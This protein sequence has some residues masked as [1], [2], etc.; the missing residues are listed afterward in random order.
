MSTQDPR[1]PARYPPIEPYE[2]GMLDVGDG[3]AST[4]RSAAT[5]PASRRWCCTAARAPAAAPGFGATP[6]PLATGSC[7][8]TSGIA[9]GAYRTP[10][11]RRPISSTNTTE[12]LLGDLE[13]F[14]AP[15]HR[16]LAPLRRFV[17]G[18]LGLVYAERHPDRVSEMVLTSIATGR[19]AETDL[20]TRGLGVMFPELGPFRGRRPRLGPRRPPRRRLRPTTGRPRP[21]GS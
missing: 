10:A 15:G 8:S 13:G 9:A 16:A 6:I 1:L 21:A 7:S 11:I 20:L 2:H 19:G 5:R 17:G 14:R 4:G 18:A 3:S 12:H